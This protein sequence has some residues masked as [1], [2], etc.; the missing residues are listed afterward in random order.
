MEIEKKLEE[1]IKAEKDRRAKEE[2]AKEVSEEVIKEKEQ[3]KEEKTTLKKKEEKEDI[4]EERI[5]TVP[6][7]KAWIS[8]RS[9]HSPRA[10]RILKS[11]VIKHMKIDDDLIL[12]GGALS[13]LVKKIKFVHVGL[14]IVVKSQTGL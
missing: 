8:P 11:F 10:I 7:S 5:Y 12:L 9:R 14:F 4:I 1:Q 2:K 13:E 3:V 6:L